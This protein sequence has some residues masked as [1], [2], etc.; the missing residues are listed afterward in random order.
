MKIL[1]AIAVVLLAGC[2]VKAPTG[3]DKVDENCTIQ[4][5]VVMKKNKTLALAVGCND[6]PGLENSNLLGCVNDAI[7]MGLFFND[8]FENCLCSVYTDTL[9]TKNRIIS[10]LRSMVNYAVAD[11][12]ITRILFSVS[13]HGTQVR[14]KDGDESD[15]ADEAVVCRD[16]AIKG[17]GIDPATVITDDEL[18]AIFTFVPD[19]VTVEVWMDCCFSGTGLRKVN[20]Q[21]RKRFYRNAEISNKSIAVTKFKPQAPNVILWSGCTDN[22][23]SADSYIDGQSRGAMTYSFLQSFSEKKT[24]AKIN[25]EMIKFMKENDFDQTPQLECSKELS[26]KVMV[27]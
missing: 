13:S 11:K 4:N 10:S 8:N 15:G 25:R 14:D 6:F 22:Q 18:H 2:G 19:R 3:P 9:A 7:M 1:I 26:N 12:N 23:Y 16:T 5:E 17:I 20:A 21:H 27:K 24:R